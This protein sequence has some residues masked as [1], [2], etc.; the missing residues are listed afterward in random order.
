MYIYIYNVHLCGHIP[1]EGLARVW[2]V[3]AEQ[4]EHEAQVRAAAGGA[5]VVAH[6]QKKHARASW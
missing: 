1:V 2:V 3:D 6:L 5:V 4:A